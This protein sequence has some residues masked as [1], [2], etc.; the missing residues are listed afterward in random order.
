MRYKYQNFRKN[1]QSETRLAEKTLRERIRAFGLERWDSLSDQQR[2]L[3]QKIWG[4]LTYKWRWQIAMNIP[5]LAIFLLDR[6]IPSVHKFDMA[7]IASV[8]S[9]LPIPELISKT[10]GLN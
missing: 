8:T 2:N 5:Y 10:L 6:T 7:L 3:L 1:M 9:R 4:V